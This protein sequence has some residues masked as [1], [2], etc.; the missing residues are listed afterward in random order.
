LKVMPV[1]MCVLGTDIEIAIIIMG[2][3]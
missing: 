1:I 2:I 3:E